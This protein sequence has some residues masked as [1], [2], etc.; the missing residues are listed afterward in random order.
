M[1]GW[2]LKSL[3]LLSL[4][5]PSWCAV[6]V[7]LVR[8]AE[9]PAG[10]K[11]PSLTPEGKARAQLLAAMLRSTPLAKIFVSDFRRTQETAQPVA[12]ISHVQLEKRTKP[13]D[14]VAAIHAVSSGT[15]LVAGH[16]N[17]V[18]Q[19]ISALGGPAFQIGEA[20]FDNL[21]IVTLDHGHVSTLRLKYGVSTAGVTLGSLKA[22]ATAYDTPKLDSIPDLPDWKRRD[23]WYRMSTFEGSG[24]PGLQAEREGQAAV[25]ALLDMQSRGL[26]TPNPTPR[27]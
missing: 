5:C 25:V 24:I 2:L 7:I 15:I 27:D 11:D 21:F 14:L 3:V 13:E 16:S 6:T 18:P 22:S 4:A 10:Q 26:E 9:I 12:A 17:T 1:R 23:S 20:D 19:V 8:H